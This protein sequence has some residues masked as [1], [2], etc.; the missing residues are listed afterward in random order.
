[1]RRYRAP[2]SGPDTFFAVR[3]WAGCITNMSGFDLR[4]AQGARIEFSVKLLPYTGN[5]H[6]VEDALIDLRKCL[7]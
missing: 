6:W 5:D 4:Q 2:L 1:M 3:S 7:H